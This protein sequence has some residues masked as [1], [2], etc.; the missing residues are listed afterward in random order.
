MKNP[1]ALHMF[2]TKTKLNMNLS[3]QI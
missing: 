3:Y 1:H 2:I